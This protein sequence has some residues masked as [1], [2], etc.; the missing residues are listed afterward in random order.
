[1]SV[2]R[3]YLHIFVQDFEKGVLFDMAIEDSLDFELFDPISQKYLVAL[4]I[5][6]C[7]FGQLALVDEDSPARNNSGFKIYTRDV[8]YFLT[9]VACC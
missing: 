3:A 5:Q 1:M 4:P 2:H 9:D 7:A 6:E 8:G